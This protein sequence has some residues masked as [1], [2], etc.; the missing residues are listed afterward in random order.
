[1]L[2]RSC[3]NYQEL[4]LS[5]CEF[6][7]CVSDLKP[8]CLKVLNL[9]G[10]AINDVGI[11]KFLRGKNAQCLEQL[12]L[13]SCDRETSEYVTN[14]TVILL[15]KYCLNLK[16]LKI[17]WRRKISDVAV[18]FLLKLK[19]LSELDLSLTSITAEGCSNLSKFSSVEKLDLSACP[20]GK[21][22]LKNLLSFDKTSKLTHLYLRF[23]RDVDEKFLLYLRDLMPKL[24]FLNIEHCGLTRDSLIRVIYPLQLRGVDIKIERNAMNESELSAV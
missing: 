24:K 9:R 4:D 18:R 10:T 2:S 23:N 22:G 6:I 11:A 15:S 1:L 5:Y 3:D 19:E 13:S 7:E 8:L 21:T 14:N 16:V 20:I 12:D 17:G